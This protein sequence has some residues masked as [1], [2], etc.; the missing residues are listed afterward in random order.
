M[1]YKGFELFPYVPF[2]DGQNNIISNAFVE[3]GKETKRQNKTILTPTNRSF[4]WTFSAKT[5]AEA[6]AFRAFF[7]GKKGRLTPFWLPSFKRDI[8]LITQANMGTITL[9]A[10]KALRNFGMYGQKRH[11]Y[12]PT[13][14]FAAK[15]NAVTIID[16]TVQSDEILTIDTVLT[17]NVYMQV[18]EYLFLVR[19]NSDEFVLEKD[20]TRFKT[21]FNFIELQ[22]ETP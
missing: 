8:T 20:G 11:I 22:G 18:I 4:Q 10:K 3:V 16:A 7:E 15:I 13:L 21:T 1:T 9:Y 12:I 5:L 2:I 17:N 14:G 6:K 19:F